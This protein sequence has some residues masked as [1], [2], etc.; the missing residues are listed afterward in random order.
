MTYAKSHS[1]QVYHDARKSS[2]GDL[3]PHEPKS[4]LA[5]TRGV[6]KL[7]KEDSGEQNLLL[8]ENEELI[9]ETGLD[10]TNW[11]V[12]ELVSD[13]EVDRQSGRAAGA[14]SEAG[15]EVL[16]WKSGK[17][18]K[19]GLGQTRDLSTLARRE[20]LSFAQSCLLKSG[21]DP[22]SV[23]QVGQRRYMS[24]RP[25]ETQH[26]PVG[27]CLDLVVM[28]T[29]GPRP[30]VTLNTLHSL[31]SAGT[32]ITCLTA[33]D[34]STALVSE[35]AGIDM[36]L[37]G[38]SLS[39]VAM[40]HSSTTA[41]T[42][43]EMI[44]HCKIVTRGAKSP[45]VF[46][47][48]PFG[49]FEISVEDGVRNAIRMIKESGIEGVKIEG[50]R[51]IVPLVKRLSEVGI[52][53]IPHIGLQPQRAVSMSGYLVQGKTSHSAHDIYETARLMQEAGAQ[54]ILLEAIPHQLGSYITE[55][56]DLI[57]IGIGA[58]GGTQA[59]VLVITDVLGT[60]AAPLPA[61]GTGT[62]TAGLGQGQGQTQSK[63]RFVRHF[64]R[65]GDEMR[66]AVEGYRDAVKQ[67]SFPEGK[68]SYGI[69]KEEWE[70]FLRLRAEGGGRGK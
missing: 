41:I 14:G 42:L 30:K 47:D 46:A 67:G 32:P 26:A 33:F 7:V 12:A 17:I 25:V 2:W 59:Q 56:L 69:K 28:L 45:F 23:V 39:Q 16:T 24:A 20:W 9:E 63:P 18:W 52:P 37:V 3:F 61:T 29:A 5:R 11:P 65:V 70:G 4:K 15:P 55:S 43:D 22:S 68:E 38:D 40:G 54:I 58:G 60:Y 57:T 10:T 66:R 64:G 53:V 50:G 13:S 49:T 8:E 51:E 27:K 1:K 6:R 31:A 44:H 48:M 35:T 36:V 19:Q 62:A 21:S 34:Y